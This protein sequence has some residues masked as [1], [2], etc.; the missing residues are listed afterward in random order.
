MKKQVLDLSKSLKN[1]ILR[2]LI[3]DLFLLF[4][5]TYFPMQNVENIRVSISSVVVSPVI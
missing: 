5:A 4:I 1:K 2:N 3:K